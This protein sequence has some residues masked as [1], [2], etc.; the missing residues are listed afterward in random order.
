MPAHGSAHELRAARIVFDD[1][2][3]EDHVRDGCVRREHLHLDVGHIRR[4]ERR[5][6]L[7]ET[8][9]LESLDLREVPNECVFVGDR[10]RVRRVEANGARREQ[11][12]VERV[13]REEVLRRVER[14]LVIV[15]S[16][17]RVR[18]RVQL[19][20]V[21]VDVIPVHKFQ[22]GERL[23]GRWSAHLGDGLVRA[24][25]RGLGGETAE[26]IVQRELVRVEG[27]L[28]VQARDDDHDRFGSLE[29]PSLRRAV[30]ELVPLG[31]VEDVVTLA[32]VPSQVRW[33][34][35]AVA[36]ASTGADRPGDHAQRHPRLRRVAPQVRRVEQDVRA[37]PIEDRIGRLHAGQPAE[38]KDAVARDAVRVDS[39]VAH[40][41]RLRTRIARAVPGREPGVHRLRVQVV[42]RVRDVREHEEPEP[43]LDGIDRRTRVEAV[44]PLVHE[45]GRA[46][47]RRW[48]QRGGPQ[49]D[50]LRRV[51]ER[52]A[53][54]V[55]GKESEVLVS[56]ALADVPGGIRPIEEP[57]GRREESVV[58]MESLDVGLRGVRPP[59]GRHVD[60]RRDGTK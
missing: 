11:E 16:Y 52:D 47:A 44:R 8:R 41:L 56:P 60:D 42:V 27:V 12:D 17:R 1:D 49:D 43:G 38:R 24:V 5:R 2:V 3:P 28:Q 37:V 39:V 59:L 23:G 57:A 32:A 55:R 40:L 4:L 22:E 50:A 35:R 54:H 21:D 45:D 53:D 30:P 33:A 48:G 51:H 10:D 18:R 19:E 58:R 9:V 15:R 46:R 7:G 36:P 31:R 13:L 25:D 29:R 26:R 6:R 20:P 14:R 34:A